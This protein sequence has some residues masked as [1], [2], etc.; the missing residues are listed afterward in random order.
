MAAV[1]RPNG[2]FGT[3]AGI[4]PFRRRLGPPCRGTPRAPRCAGG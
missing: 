1:V 3:M 4:T 2:R